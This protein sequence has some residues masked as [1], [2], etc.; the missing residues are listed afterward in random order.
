VPARVE[1]FLHASDEQTVD[2]IHRAATGVGGLNS[3]GI[4]IREKLRRSAD[5]RNAIKLFGDGRARDAQR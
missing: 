1:N 4:F 3:T 2:E 5:R